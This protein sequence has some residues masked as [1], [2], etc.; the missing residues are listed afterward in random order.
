MPLF[1]LSLAFLVGVVLGKLL[2]W[3]LAAWLSLAGL[4]AIF[5]LLRFLL[6]RRPSATAIMD[7]TTQQPPARR[8]L[9]LPYAVLACA[10]ALGAARYEL[11]RPELGPGSIA[12]YTDHI[13]DVL[14][15]G[16]LVEPPLARDRSLELRVQSERVQPPHSTGYLPVGGLLLVRLPPG[17]V[18]RYGDRISLQGALVTPPELEDFS[19][20]EYLARQGIYAYLPDARPSL[21]ARGQGNRLMAVLYDFKAHALRT[22]YR[23][24]PDP[25]ASLLAGILLGVDEGIPESVRQAFNNSGTAHIIAISGFKNPETQTVIPQSHQ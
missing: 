14:V 8:L 10:V 25:E 6:A 20:R 18:W 22:I 15:E 9:P 24:F 7:G 17:G 1:W 5:A 21:L 2:A 19:Y 13:G 16:V 4:A 23:L 12:W 11:S 3:P